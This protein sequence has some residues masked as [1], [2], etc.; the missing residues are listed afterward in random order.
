M[1]PKS[2]RSGVITD[3]YDYVLQVVDTDGVASDQLNGTITVQA[4]L[5]PEAA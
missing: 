1:I 4:S 2:E 3:V 5:F